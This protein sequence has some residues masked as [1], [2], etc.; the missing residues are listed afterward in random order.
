M[1][2]L[3]STCPFCACGC[4]VL[5]QEEDGRL[6]A[7]FPSSAPPARSGLC[8]RG[9]HCTGPVSAPDRLAS[10]LIRG[11]AG[12]VRASWQDAVSEIAG[13]LE[14]AQAPPGF[15]VGPTVANEDAAAV[16]RLAERLDGRLC[17]SDL[18][19]AAVARRA[20]EQ[21]APGSR[22]LSDP[23][24]IARADLVWTIGF[25]AADC[26]Q[27]AGRVIDARRRG[28]S[29]VRFDV[30]LAAADLSRVVTMPPDRF[31]E[32]EFA[33]E[34]VA[35]FRAATRPV[36][37]VGG[38]WLT[39]HGAE[40]NTIALLRVL[41]PLGAIDRVV[42]AVG[43]SNS[44]GV[45]DVLGPDAPAAEIACRDGAL[46]TLVVV[47]DDVV[48][49]SPRPGSMA[50]A[51][52]RLTSLV[53]ID[54]FPTEAT[55]LADVVLP[56]CTFAEADGW[57]TNLFGE[58]RPWRRI[59]APPGDAQ[60]ERV[61]MERIAAAGKAEAL[62][63]DAAGKAKALPYDTD[64]P[65]S[66]QATAFPFHLVLSSHPAAFSTGVMTSRD[67]ILRREANES[68]LTAS[69]GALQAAGLKPGWPARLIVPDGEVTI[70]VR[71]DRR[72]PD[73]VLV[74]VPIPGSAAAS[75]RGCHPADGGCAVGLQPVPAR[76]ERA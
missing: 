73:A 1:A 51:L 25:D 44:W 74:L 76:L 9:W 35:E 17:T 48:R 39:S 23:E 33:A 5:L 65:R 70:T 8:I 68:V 11:A 38:R 28:A 52:S 14:A 31:G 16:R 47:A 75:M 60:P 12:L 29:V 45:L 58:A 21:A 63:Y 56:S 41:A 71:A 54:R 64:A 43:E 19:G 34:L 20:M 36:V 50:H 27:V 69:P 49:R 61:W 22:G 67:D 59:V 42:F 30:H 24:A 32:L 15:L 55:A 66:G 10:P 26:P 7:S 53:V 4:G 13:R 18:T 37:I 72:L 57:V 46:D 40:A 3:P 6:V 62:P 2:C